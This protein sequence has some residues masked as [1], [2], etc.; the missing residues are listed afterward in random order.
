VFIRT[1]YQIGKQETFAMRISLSTYRQLLRQYLGPQRGAALLM[2]ALLL[3]SIGLQLAGPQVARAFID[4]ARAG[5][6]EGALAG[7][8]LLFIGVALA[9]QAARVLAT[10]WSERVAWNATNALRADLAAHLLRLDLGFHTARTPGELIERVDG[11]VQALAGFFSSFVVQLLG[12]A[13]LMLGVLAAVALLDARL[14]LAFILFAALALG[15]LR[16]VRR[17]ATPHWR[18]DRAWSASFYGFVGEALTAAEDLRANGAGPYALRRF[19]E[20]LR[21]WMPVR[22]RAELW[23]SAVWIAA[24]AVFA[25]GDAL[26]YGLGG[27]LHRAGAISLGAVYLVVAYTAMLAEP[28]ETIRTQIQDLQRADAGIARV[29]ELLEVRSKL[30][31]GT[32]DLPAGALAI[33]L[34][35]VSFGYGDEPEAGDLRLET[36]ESVQ[37]SSLKPQASMVLDDISFTLAPGRTLGLLGRTGSGKTT[38]ARLLFRLYDPQAGA[39]R[40][41]GVDLRWARLAA[42][43]G[44]VGMVTQDVQLFAAT[45][46][47]N[48]TFFDPRVSDARLRE[49]LEALGLEAW[50]ARLP[51]GLDTPISATS[52]SAGEAQLVALARVFLKDPGLV[53][54]DEA[55]SRLDP[56]TEALLGRALARLLDGRTAVIIAHRL[57]TVERADDILILQDGRVLEHGP[58]KLLAADPR[59]RFAE[60]RR[61]G[62]QEVLA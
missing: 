59:S 12:S 1:W 47:D 42:L 40:L 49:V 32:A 41:G 8:A 56:A 53:I 55:S 43:R 16:W 6:P 51:R 61:A 4:G 35:R 13:L 3:A 27:G 10:Y 48:I 20:Q 28:I 29:R 34:E 33:E 9:Q 5:A 25:F 36:C 26:A 14:G 58:R 23:S 30:E 7:M 44:R 17:F 50:L 62:L 57:A 60:L 37:A 38:L 52:L 15:V 21:G 2:A 19:F 39:V 18:D 46:R 11:D 31:D 22:M 24:V 45:L 54:L